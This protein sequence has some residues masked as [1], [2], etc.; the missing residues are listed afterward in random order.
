[1]DKMKAFYNF[2]KEAL[3]DIGYE[4]TLNE[5]AATIY[6]TGSSDVDV[7]KLENEGYYSFTYA[8]G[9]SDKSEAELSICAQYMNEHHSE[10]FGTMTNN[11]N[12]PFFVIC[13]VFSC[14]D[15]DDEQEMGKNLT[16]KYMETKKEIIGLM[17]EALKILRK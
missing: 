15:S 2:A 10:R 14:E 8:S 1:M 3:K 13:K 9:F 7:I 17:Q 16:I 4:I 5:N 11:V 6:S 12:T